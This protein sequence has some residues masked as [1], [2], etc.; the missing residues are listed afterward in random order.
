MARL[1]TRVV[2]IGRISRVRELIF[3]SFAKRVN[4]LRWQKKKI[5]KIVLRRSR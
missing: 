2:W 4:D 5:E 3:Q 1:A